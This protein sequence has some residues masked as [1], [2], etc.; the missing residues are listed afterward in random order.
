V[1]PVTGDGR[2]G[3]A[4]RRPVA[5]VVALLLVAV[6]G[7]AVVFLS[8]YALGA[9]VS[10]TPGTPADQEALWAPFWDAYRAITDQFVGEVDE[11]KLVEGAI[12][13]MVTSLGDRW[14]QY[15]TSEQYR[16]S[17][18]GIS[19]RFSGIGAEMQGQPMPSGEPCTPLGPDCRLTVITTVPG[20]PAEKAGLLPGDAVVA[21]DG[22]SLDGLTADEATGKIRGPKGTPVTLTIVRGAEAPRD[23]TIVRDYIARP[24][25]QAKTLAD[26]TVGYVKLSGFSDSAS[27]AFAAAVADLSSQG[28]KRFVV[29]IRG[30][31][32]GFVSAARDIAS[33][34]IGSGPVYFQEDARGDRIAVEAKPGGAATGGDVRVVALI[35]GNSASASEILAGALQDTGRGTLVGSRSFGKGTIQEWLPLPNDMGGMRLTVLKWLTPGGRWIHDTGIEPDI[36]VDAAAAGGSPDPVLDRALEVLGVPAGSPAASATPIP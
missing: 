11:K 34:F 17:L 8:G 10:T 30:N 29:D 4:R 18:Q 25:V 5:T 23:V 33:Q 24:E 32:G 27:K 31:P 9:R 13:G 15:L 22:S 3:R 28:V 6:M 35:D 21:V 20:A 12:N 1:T 7:G 19:G 14:S 36:A 16:D 26:G 2:A